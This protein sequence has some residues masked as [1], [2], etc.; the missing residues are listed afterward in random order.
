MKNHSSDTVEEWRTALSVLGNL[1]GWDLTVPNRYQGQS[2]QERVSE[3]WKQLNKPRLGVSDHLVG[4]DDHVDE[5]MDLL[6]MGTEDV[7]I[8]GIC[9]MGGVGKTTIAKLVYNQLMDQFEH[10]SFLGNIREKSLPPNGMESLQRQLVLDILR[11][12]HEEI[13]NVDRGKGVLKDRL[14]YRKVLIVYDDV[15]RSEQLSNLLPDLHFCAPGSWILVTT[16]N[17]SVLDESRGDQIYRVTELNQEDAFLLFCKHAFRQNFPIAEFADLSWQIAK[18]TGGLPLAIEVLGSY[19]SS[20]L[21]EDI[22]REALDRLR[23]EQSVQDRLRISFD[24]L[25]HDEREIFL[26]IACL[27]AG[28]DNRVLIHMFKACGFSPESALQDLC[29]RSLIKIGD[30][31]EVWMHDQVKDLGREIVRQENYGEPEERSRLWRYEDAIEVLECGEGTSKVKAICVHHGLKEAETRFR[32]EAFEKLTRL[33]FLELGNSNFQEHFQGRLQRLKWLSWHGHTLLN[34]PSDLHLK[35]LVVL[36]LSKSAIR[37]DWIGWSSVQVLKKLEVVNLTGCQELTGTPHFFS[38]PP[39]RKL[40]L[41]G[42]HALVAV[43]QSIGH[44]T[45]LESLS[46]KNCCS[47]EQLP[48]E[49]GSLSSL[50]ELVVDGTLV[51]EIPMSAGMASLKILSAKWCRS[52]TLIPASIE[53]LK[54]LQHLFL[55]HCGSLREIPSSIGELQSLEELNLSHTSVRHLPDSVGYLSKLRVLDISHSSVRSFPHS[56]WKLQKLEVL[57]ASHCRRLAGAVPF[58]LKCPT[59]L[60]VLG[61]GYTNVD[62]LPLSIHGLSHLQTLDFKRCT[63]LRTLPELPFSLVNLKVTC[64]TPVTVL[65]NLAGLVNLNQ[66]EIVQ[67]YNVTQIP[68]EIGALSQLKGLSIGDYPGL[69]LLPQL[70]SSLR[71]LQLSHLSSLVRLPNLSKLKKLSTFLLWDC[72]RIVKIPGLKKMISLK[73]LTVKSP[74]ANLDGL[75]SLSALSYLWVEGWECKRLP[76]LSELKWIRDITV[77]SCDNLV[78]IQALSSLHTLRTLSIRDCKLLKELLLARCG[79]LGQGHIFEILELTGL[80]SLETLEVHGCD[81]IEMLRELSSLQKLKKLVLARCERLQISELTG[82]TSLETLKVHCC[83]AIEMLPELSSLQK[84]KELAL[85]GCGRLGQIPELTGLTSLETLKVRGCGAIEMLPELSS[86]QKLKELVLVY[87]RGLGRIPELTR[88]TSLETLRVQSCNAIEMLPKLSSLQK[89]K[90]LELACCGQLGQILELTGLT[91]LETLVVQD[92]YAIEMLPELSSLQK[93]KKLAL[94]GCERLGQI[95]ELTGLTSLEMLEVHGCNAIEMLPELSSLQKLKKLALASCGRL[96]QIPELTGLR[97]LEI[98]EIRKCVGIEMLPDLS[99][100][101][102]LEQLSLANNERLG[103]IPELTG[104]ASLKI[105]DISGC[106]AIE[107]LPDISSL[108]KLD[109]LNLA[110]CKRLRQIPE[111]TGLALLKLLIIHGCEA[112]EILPEVS[113]RCEVI[114]GAD[115]GRLQTY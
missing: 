13:A 107:M 1:K 115:R 47:L 93:L 36:D 105:L 18:A 88:L 3:V 63:K 17:I 67:C 7:R 77:R 84:L 99:S 58:E 49:L 65:A 37:R 69:K 90:N 70:P 79:R 26:D 9:G 35:N 42:C 82:L 104:L 19:L 110:C 109:K 2:V 89:L 34:I 68:Q 57:N 10:C 97:S 5:V 74:L 55:N 96:G 8:V 76:N 25:N 61:L 32:G 30:D 60:R 56:L 72:R 24:A 14:R 103:R 48:E 91:S 15:D 92:C 106:G 22:W 114:G 54:E 50:A 66:L 62:E 39:I 33:L 108:C 71:G 44:L 81:T 51:Q 87:C 6:N 73:K 46:L 28:M 38:F 94:A 20:K 101:R 16:R 12:K 23:K 59:F 85:A 27:Y 45:S 41:D 113:S 112:I 75:G 29:L 98:L 64:P 111:L 80:T 40:I 31:K 11:H 83:D 86:C 52:L 95:P 21:Q 78:E 53:C 43:H 102:K 4:V 100:L